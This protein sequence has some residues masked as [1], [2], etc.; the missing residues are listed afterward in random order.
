M[1]RVLPKIPSR[2]LSTQRRLIRRTEPALGLRL[3]SLQPRLEPK[4]LLEFEYR[5]Q[6]VAAEEIE[7]LEVSV[8]WL[9][10]GKGTTDLGVHFFASF[11]GQQLESIVSKPQL[12]VTTLPTCPLTFAGDLFS[13]RWCIRLRLY[14]RDGSEYAAEREFALGHLD[15]ED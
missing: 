15:F 4:E 14:L 6:R 2:R 13:I 10:E 3:L 5:V 9:T 12:I 7:R 11:D 8:L 1:A